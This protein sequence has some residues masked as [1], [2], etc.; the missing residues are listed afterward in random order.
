M[1]A[2]RR[3]TAEGL[4]ELIPR[5]EALGPAGAQG[6]EQARAAL[7]GLAEEIGAV[8]E[9]GSRGLAGSLS[10]ILADLAV[11]ARSTAD[12]FSAMARAIQSELARLL[13]ER[14]F[15]PVFGPLF[16]AILPAFGLARGG[17]LSGGALQPFAM[18]GVPALSVLRNT[19]VDRPVLFPM[20]N[21]EMGLAGEAG[22][23]AI[24]PLK[25]G[26]V[27][28]ITPAGETILPLAR[29]ASGHLAV[30]LDMP[31]GEVVPFARGGVPDWARVPGPPPATPRDRATAGADGGAPPR[32]LRVEIINH[33]AARGEEVSVTQEQEADGDLL[34]IVIDRVDAA[35]AENARRGRGSLTAALGGVFGM[36]R[37]PR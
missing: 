2:A 12:A 29:A 28:A 33:G 21:G 36:R 6:A 20:A 14:V 22:P 9:A 30:R 23:E 11:G 18:G 4:A 13:Q 24:L 17:V 7:A 27:R 32:P 31:S 35:L 5:L 34:R 1:A 37:V 26:G 16:D 8:A 3:R 19:V 15:A 10:G 25:G